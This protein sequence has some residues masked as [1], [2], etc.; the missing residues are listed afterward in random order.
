MKFYAI[1]VGG[2]KTDF[3]R[4]DVH[5]R[6]NCIADYENSLIVPGNISRMVA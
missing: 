4:I 2:T 5:V 3:A 6:K 1:D